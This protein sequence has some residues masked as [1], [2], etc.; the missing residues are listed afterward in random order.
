MVHNLGNQPSDI[1][2]AVLPPSSHRL[3][4]IPPPPLLHHITR[5]LITRGGTL[6]SGPSRAQSPPPG[7]HAYNILSYSPNTHYVYR[8]S[9]CK[10]EIVKYRFKWIYMTELMRTCW[11]FFPCIFTNCQKKWI[12]CT[13]L[14]FLQHSNVGYYISKAPVIFH[15]RYGPAQSFVLIFIVNIFSSSCI[16]CLND[17]HCLSHWKPNSF[18]SFC[19]EFKASCSKQKSSGT[20]QVIE[21]FS[22]QCWCFHT[23]T[24]LYRR[25][26]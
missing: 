1:N 2:T 6:G 21:H 22:E 19:T 20:L 7:Q 4:S 8:A 17:K 23:R 18:T 5:I 15:W 16:R 10:C 11:I 9:R 14:W 26:F 24:E 25:D 13:H 3:S 12:A